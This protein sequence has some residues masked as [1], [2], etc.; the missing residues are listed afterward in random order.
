MQGPY[1]NPHES[2]ISESLKSIFNSLNKYLNENPDLP[3]L[4]RGTSL[5]VEPPRK[6]SSDTITWTSDYKLSWSDFKGKNPSGQYMAQSNCVFDYR[7]E[8]KMKNGILELHLYL[9]ACFE[10]K[11]SWVKNGAQ[12]D[13]L[14]RHEQ[15]HFDICEKHIRSLRN[16]MQTA[17]LN[18]MEFS[19]VLNKLMEEV[20]N[21][22]QIDQ[23]KYD[24]ETEHGIKEKEQ[25]R[26]EEEV[27]VLLK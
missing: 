17:I 22:Y 20:W 23:Q 10:R 7:L 15:L 8:P 21:E 18:P 13:A 12:N 24:A 6:Y 25:K 16:K 19:D 1:A 4:A 27:G 26:W 3:P 5:I 9:G 11:S 2:N 14:L